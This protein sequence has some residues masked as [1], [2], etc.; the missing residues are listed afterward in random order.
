MWDGEGVEGGR[1][2]CLSLLVC[3]VLVSEQALSEV[4]ELE[5]EVTALRSTREQL[6]GVQGDLQT[7]RE[8]CEQAQAQARQAGDALEVGLLLGWRQGVVRV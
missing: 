7:V 1:P 5:A 8:A 4:C 2:A 3:A 6:G